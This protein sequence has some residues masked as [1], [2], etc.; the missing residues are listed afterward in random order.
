M[1]G[2][3]SVAERGLAIYN[4]D[5]YYLLHHGI[6]SPPSHMCNAP[7]DSLISPTTKAVLPRSKVAQDKWTPIYLCL[8][9]AC[10]GEEQFADFP[11]ISAMEESTQTVLFPALTNSMFQPS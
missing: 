9:W 3:P 2:K 10:E 1:R 6:S 8:T 4:S 7:S 5:I 11:P